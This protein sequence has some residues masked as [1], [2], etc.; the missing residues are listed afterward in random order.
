MSGVYLFC[1]KHSKINNYKNLAYF[2]GK[3]NDNK[4]KT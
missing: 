2:F 1:L 3:K 4:Q